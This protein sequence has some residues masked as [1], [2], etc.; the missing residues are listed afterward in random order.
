MFQAGYVHSNCHYQPLVRSFQADLEPRWVTLV[1][2]QLVAVEE[3]RRKGALVEIHR[4]PS[5]ISSDF[6]S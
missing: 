4:H 5:W 3:A 6:C 2:G 1:A